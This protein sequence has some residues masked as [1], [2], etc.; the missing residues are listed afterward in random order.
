MSTRDDDDDRDYE[1]GYGR[2]PK[3]TQFRKGQSG[4]PNGRP[5][6][7]KGFA[8]S[9]RRELAAQITVR[10]GNRVIRIAKRDAAAKRLVEKALNGDTG[11]LRMLAVID[12]D[13]SREVEAAMAAEVKSRQPDPGDLEI[14][15]HFAQ[16]AQAGEWSPDE[17]EEDA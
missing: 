17:E 11:A 13:L 6:G 12:V 16:M 1:V 15:R 10:E 3:A 5:K 9:L 8:A 4:N 2:P 7:A 14:L